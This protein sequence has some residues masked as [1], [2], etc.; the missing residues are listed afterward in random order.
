MHDVSAVTA[1][2]RRAATRL[3]TAPGGGVSDTAQ[4]PRL[5]ASPPST[6]LRAKTRRFARLGPGL[7]VSSRSGQ[8]IPRLALR[9]AL[10]GLFLLVLC[11]CLDIQGCN[12][13]AMV[14]RLAGQDL[15]AAL[16]VHMP[17]LSTS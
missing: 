7:H 16:P 13:S 12:R 9:C 5:G 14:Q 11:C 4:T 1:T 3:G 17:S 10:T 8:R 15:A 6:T 2:A